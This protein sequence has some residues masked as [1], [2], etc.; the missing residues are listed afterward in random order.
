MRRPPWTESLT[1]QE[2]ESV[3][4]A[5]LGAANG[6]YFPNW[7]FEALIGLDREEVRREAASWPETEDWT[8]QATA[9]INSL[10]NLLYY[11]HGRGIREY[12]KSYP[13]KKLPQLLNKLS[14][15]A[16]PADQR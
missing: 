6:R 9:A 5:M 11:P 16:P 4:E 12:V 15:L 2:V 7:E 13:S 10:N 8:S 14:A 1:D 3:R